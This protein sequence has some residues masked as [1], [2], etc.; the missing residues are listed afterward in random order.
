MT[1]RRTRLGMGNNTIA[2]KL[3]LGYTGFTRPGRSPG[4]EMSKGVT[5]S[6]RPGRSPGE[7][8]SKGAP[9]AVRSMRKGGKLWIQEATKNKGSLHRSLHVPEGKKIPLDK[10]KKAEHSQSPTLRKRAKLAETLRGFHHRS[11]GR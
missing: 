4:L 5:T 10:I 8:A 6:I 11:Q 7:E 2:N 9:L 1:A 3:S